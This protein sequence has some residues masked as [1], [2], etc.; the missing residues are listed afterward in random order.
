MNSK[1]IILVAV[2]LAIFATVVKAQEEVSTVVQD[3]T[4]L[5]SIT[6]TAVEDVTTTETSWS[7]NAKEDELSSNSEN[8]ELPQ[9]NH[10]Q[11]NVV[12]NFILSFINK[13]E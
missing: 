10:G 6:S 8:E 13:H 7:D 4:E 9:H 5:S 12:F 11:N 2:I 3:V 1:S